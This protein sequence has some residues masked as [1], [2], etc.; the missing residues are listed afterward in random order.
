VTAPPGRRGTPYVVSAPSGTGKTSV[1]RLVVERDPHIEFSVSH[2]T[3][4]PRPGEREGVD[5]H[6]VSAEEFRALAAEDAFVEHAEYGGNLYGTSW[7]SLDAPLARGKDLLLEIEVQGARQIRARR[8]D[9]RFLFLLPPSMEELARR[10]RG[11][12]TDDEAQ[13]ERRL[14][15][16]RAELRAVHGFDYAVVNDQL[17]LAATSVCEII[18]AERSGDPFSARERFGTSGVVSKLSDRLDFGA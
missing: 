11:R 5:Y 7:R 16:A 10:L 1:C 18:Q 13:V 17:E 6:F 9:A 12:G 14:E 15:M 8:A 3:R 4:V 2:T